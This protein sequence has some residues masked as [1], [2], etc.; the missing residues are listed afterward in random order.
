MPD[1]LALIYFSGWE[2][3][4]KMK[5]GS[6]QGGRREAKCVMET[7]CKW[8][9]KG[10][11]KQDRQYLNTARAEDWNQAVQAVWWGGSKH[12]VSGHFL[13]LLVFL[14]GP[15]H[16]LRV[17]THISGFRQTSTFS[18]WIHFP[19]PLHFLHW[20]ASFY[21]VRRNHCP[22]QR[23]FQEPFTLS[24][25]SDSKGLCGDMEVRG[26][27]QAPVVNVYVSSNMW[28]LHVYVGL[29]MIGY[30]SWSARCPYLIP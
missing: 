25:C 23:I 10:K 7:V 22:F 11:E 21:P 14:H 4:Q 30:S 9:E 12:Q 17:N 1:H 15:M 18:F 2:D 24:C 29:C 13:Q 16:Y 6:R 28:K 20:K 27:I 3:L 19:D 5:R 8:E 26:S